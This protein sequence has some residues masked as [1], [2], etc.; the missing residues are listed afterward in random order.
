MASKEEVLQAENARLVAEMA[1]MKKKIMVALKK[2]QAEL[3]AKIQAAEQ[4]ASAAEATV[5]SANSTIAPPNAQSLPIAVREASNIEASDSVIATS[6]NTK[7]DQVS[8]GLSN[9]DASHRPHALQMDNNFGDGEMVRQGLL[10]EIE[11]L[12]VELEQQKQDKQKECGH[13]EQELTEMKERYQCDTKEKDQAVSKLT[14]ELSQSRES[15]QQE[16]TQLRETNEKLEAQLLAAAE[17]VSDAFTQFAATQTDMQQ[18]TKEGHKVNLVHAELMQDYQRTCDEL[19][20]T[21]TALNHAKNEVELKVQEMEQINASRKAAQEGQEAAVA[22]LMQRLQEMES[23]LG[24]QDVKMEAEVQGKQELLQKENEK[25]VEQLQDQKKII[26]DLQNEIAELQERAKIEL[27]FSQPKATDDMPAELKELQ[28]DVEHGSSQ[29]LDS[30]AKEVSSLK[31]MLDESRTSQ[32]A[33]EDLV[34]QLKIAHSA[35]EQKV[36]KLMLDQ[37]E[38]CRKMEKDI[39]IREEKYAELDAKFG[40]LQKRAKQRIQEVFLEK[41]DLEAQL[42]SMQEKSTQDLLQLTTLQGELD[43]FRSQAGDAIRLLDGERQQLRNANL[44]LKEELEGL[45]Q[46]LEA[47]EHN[48][49]ESRRLASEKDQTALRMTAEMQEA[50][51]RH[52]LEIAE[53][54]EKQQKVVHAFEDQL[55]DEALERKKLN[56]S[57]SVLQEQYAEKEAK[58]AD[59]EAVSSGE[60]VRLGAALEAAKGELA[61]LEQEH[62]NEKDTLENLV[63]NLKQKLEELE[64][65]HR[66]EQIA[67]EETQKNWEADLEGQRQALNA[68][69]VELAATRDEADYLRK[70]FTSYKVRAHALLQKKE[71]ELLAAKDSKLAAAQDLALKE[72]K[73]EA[74]AAVTERDQAVRA[75]QAAVNEYETQLAASRAVAIMDSEQRIRDLATKLESMKGQLLFQEEEFQTEL[76]KLDTSWCEK[77]ET[78]EA[79]VKSSTEA[80]SGSRVAALQEEY[81][82]L[83]AEFVSFREMANKMIESKDQ[84]I[85][86][87]LD[88]NTNL[89]QS[90]RMQPQVEHEASKQSAVELQEPSGSTLAVAEQQILLLARQQAQREEEVKQC[91]RQI[92][93]LQEEISELERENR[94]HSQQEAILKEELRNADRSQKRD[95]VDMTYVKNV[96]LKLLETGEVEALLPVIAMLLQFSPDEQRRCQEAYNLIKGDAP[97]SNS[98]APVEAGASTPRSFF[99]MLSFAGGK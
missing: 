55:A 34:K 95:G 84:E 91:L 73:R 28:A 89:Q 76:K 42:A 40:R 5:L 3:Q 67:A 97:A 80:E 54:I 11:R 35:A 47:K 41:E 2:Q 4:R 98:A 26:K 61:R 58:L 15:Y 7:A 69:Q 6:S 16:L 72:A 24:A 53:L 86:R 19:E 99:S 45:R 71:A 14:L 22:Q 56:E 85:A 83:S 74:V 32:A 18:L 29:L 38:A 60:I 94:L 78:L 49:A 77:Y 8:P 79:K 46:T 63:T 48:L 30:L 36:E 43:R 37:Q 96:I 87:L 9:G 39:L 93:A 25:L 59:V 68:A 12:K 64:K 23:S 75:L 81:D 52:K 1:S 17:Q 92:Q 65:V 10:A 51:D 27:K 88:D 82:H 57:L 90:I 33:A 66:Q 31:Q 62:K 20:T 44:K 70:E 13:L 21:R 50:D